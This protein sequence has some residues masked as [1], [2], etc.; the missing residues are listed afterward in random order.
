[1]ELAVLSPNQRREKKAE[2]LPPFSS[3]H[4]PGVNYEEK[5]VGGRAAIWGAGREKK[6]STKEKIRSGFSVKKYDERTRFSAN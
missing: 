4:S 5:R 6:S 1:M 2:P 3:S